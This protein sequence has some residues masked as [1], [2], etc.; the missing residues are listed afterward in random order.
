MRRK[1]CRANTGK[2]EKRMGGGEE[3]KTT[4]YGVD[5]SDGLDADSR[6]GRKGISVS[7]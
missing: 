2:I 5:R 1:D 4:R 7:G 6:W 3:E